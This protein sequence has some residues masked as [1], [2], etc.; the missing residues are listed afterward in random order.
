[1]SRKSSEIKS[2][3]RI[4]VHTSIAG[5]IYKSIERAR[6]LGCNTLQ[7]FSHNPR[8]WAVRDI[9]QDEIYEFVTLK[10]KYGISPVCIHTSYLINL[11]SKKRDLKKKSVKMVKFELDF[12]DRVGAEYVVL[13]TGSASGD[14]PTSAR[15]RVIEALKEISHREK[16]T[17][18]LLLENT[19]G[20]RGDITSR[21]Y[22]IAEI[23]EGVPTGLISGICLDTCHAF[24][25]GYDIRN[26]KGITILSEEI[27]KYCHQNAIKLLHLNDSKVPLG[28][29]AD[30]H[31][32]IGKGAIGA[33][34]IRKI[35]LHPGFNK[36]PVI[37]ETP[38][39]SNADDIANLRTVNKL[40]GIK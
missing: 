36:L 34:G 9:P 15:K 26:D 27:K 31:E 23:I 35:L 2:I 39:K 18:G 29:G 3:R 38:K 24:S 10:K 12:A 6:E 14:D 19:S 17:S 20:K 8:G 21:M 25:A 16:G 5:G 30:R 40:L 4:G 37:L 22:E 32:H 1:M 33:K 11:A 7:I 13:H 28:S